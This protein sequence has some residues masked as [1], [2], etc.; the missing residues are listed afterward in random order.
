M[1]KIMNLIFLLMIFNTLSAQNSSQSYSIE[2][3]LIL[4]ESQ[5]NRPFYHLIYQEKLVSFSYYYSHS[6]A[7]LN[8]FQ[9]RLKP[10]IM[11]NNEK[12]YNSVQ[13]GNSFRYWITED[14]YFSAENYIEYHPFRSADK[15]FT[16]S[17]GVSFGL[18]LKDSFFIVPSFSKTINTDYWIAQDIHRFL[19]WYIK[20]G[21]E[22]NY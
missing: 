22:W 10:G 9:Y 5:F 1:K 3:G 4:S 14:Y 12:I 15:A 18:R 20:L 17:Y 13:L 19:K 6:W 7:V 16:F 11:L 8:N 2:P 21:L